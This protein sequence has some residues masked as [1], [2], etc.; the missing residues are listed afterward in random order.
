V[1]KQLRVSHKSA[2]AWQ[3]R[4]VWGLAVQGA[5]R[6]VVPLDVGSTAHGWI[7]NQRWTLARV[8]MLIEQLNRASTS[9]RR[10]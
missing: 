2:Y 3:V 8:T 5:E 6:V 10:L 7:E 9:A 4:L 1:A